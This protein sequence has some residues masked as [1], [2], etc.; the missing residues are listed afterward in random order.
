MSVFSLQSRVERLEASA[1]GAECLDIESANA[2][3]NAV[4]SRLGGLDALNSTFG[5]PALQEA[6]RKLRAMIEQLSV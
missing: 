3:I 5:S 2:E 4:I 1:V 6:R